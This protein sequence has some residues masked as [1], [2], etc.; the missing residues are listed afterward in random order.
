MT[1]NYLIENKD[2]IRNGGL[3]CKWN[4][5]PTTI[6]DYRFLGTGDEHHQHGVRP[7]Y[8][9]ITTSDGETIELKPKYLRAAK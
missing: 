7:C 2:A 8:V 4:R 6:T 3:A 9:K 1:I 5:K